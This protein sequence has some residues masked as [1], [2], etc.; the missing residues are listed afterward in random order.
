MP[1]DVDCP[2]ML[3]VHRTAARWRWFSLA[4]FVAGLPAGVFGACGGDAVEPASGDAA[5][6]S[7]AVLP[8]DAAKDTESDDANDAYASDA[9]LPSAAL[10]IHPRQGATGDDSAAAVGPGLVLDGGFG[11]GSVLAWMHDASTGGIAARGD[12]VVL[13]H[14]A[15]DFS[16]GW[17][18]AAPFHSVQTI[19]IGEGATADDYAIAADIVSRAEVVWFTGGD[20]AKYV[21]WNKT[22]VMLAVQSVYARKGVVGG[23][24]AGMI[25]L[26]SSVND[27]TKTL[28]ENITT[29]VCVNDPYD[30]KI[31]FTQNIFSFPPLVRTITDPH[32]VAVNRMGR[33]ATFMGRQVADGFAT[34]DILGIGVAD[35]AA[36]VIDREGIGKR[37]GAGAASAYVVRGG[38]PQQI[39]AGTTLNY[40]ALHVVK[41]QSAADQYDFTRR[42]GRGFVKDIDVDGSQSPPYPADV[43]ENGPAMDECP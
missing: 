39:A 43:Y 19:S 1:D 11:G 28:S 13:T 32:F 41:L 25:I 5:S 12:V 34:P 8:G 2:F 6:D 15:G 40:P 4:L 23:S 22:P 36:L 10:H 42:C 33:L 3:L 21:A 37:L 31:H 29:A 20:Q 26:G 30:A 14:H 16:G 27:A 38:T 24:S 7:T 35:G 9:R 18:A 17:L